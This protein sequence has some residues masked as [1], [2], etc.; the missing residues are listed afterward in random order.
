MCRIHVHRIMSFDEFGFS[1]CNK[2]LVLNLYFDMLPC[3]PF[4]ARAGSITESFVQ[5]LTLDYRGVT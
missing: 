1:D 3:L 4:G 2:R 5:A